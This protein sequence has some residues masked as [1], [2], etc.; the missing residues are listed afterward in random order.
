MKT[1]RFG[2]HL[3]LILLLLSTILLSGC[4]GSGGSSPP[5]QETPRSG[6]VDRSFGTDG[7][8]ITAVSNYYDVARKILVQ[9]D[10][11][12]LV[13]GDITDGTS[14]RFAVTRYTTSGALDQTYGSNG[15]ATVEITGGGPLGGAVL[16]PDGKIVV[17]GCAYNGT[18]NDIV[19][20]RF[21][22]D[23]V[24]DETFG[25]GGLYRSQGGTNECAYAVALQRDGRV[26][27]AGFTENAIDGDLDFLLA[28]YTT[29][30][31]LDTSF[32]TNGV[33]N[34]PLPSDQGVRRECQ[35]T[36]LSVTSDDSVIAGG[37]ATIAY[38]TSAWTR[39]AIARYTSDGSLDTTFGTASLTA[40]TYANWPLD[41]VLQNDGKIV[42][43]ATQYDPGAKREEFCLIRFYQ[44]GTVDFSFGSSGTALAPIG[45]RYAA[46][47]ALA[48]Q[49]DGKF[50]VGGETYQD[51][52]YAIALARFHGNGALDSTF[53]DGGSI[54]TQAGI[55][56]SN[57]RSVAIQS[58][59]KILAAGQVET[60]GGI[61]AFGI[62][63]YHP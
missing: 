61:R 21:G 52:K 33:V 4:G 44:T 6:E 32:G 59:R 35:F 29:T 50:V 22:T 8:V 34:T 63:R 46:A 30:G 5:T 3:R 1:S 42:V 24:L 37:L 43:A 60:T 48:L 2:K 36:T 10:G 7:V 9:Q 45:D 16:Q 13:A 28:R 11:R 39:L 12:I 26:V 20:A 62:V 17:A 25:S 14:L 27:V 40:D 41:M 15:K 31:D 54:I 23:G 57:A 49:S 53:S 56:S 51:G 47:S 19:L 18:D 55:G 38:Q 58:D